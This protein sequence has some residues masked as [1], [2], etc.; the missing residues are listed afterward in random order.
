M[1]G[2]NDDVTLKL[3]SPGGVLFDPKVA[4]DDPL[5]AP[6]KVPQLVHVAVSAWP[7]EEIVSTPVPSL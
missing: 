4:A 3:R 7:D 2:T 1:I 5:A 6:N